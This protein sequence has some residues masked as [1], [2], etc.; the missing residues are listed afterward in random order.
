[1]SEVF[2]RESDLD[3]GPTREPLLEI[4]DLVKHF[5]VRRGLLGRQRHVLRAVD[6]VSLQIRRGET[7]G[8]V[9]ESGCGKSTVGRCLLQLQ[10]VTGGEIRFRGEPIQ[11]LSERALRPLR[12]HIQVVFQDPYE[13]LNPRHTVADILRE[14][15][16][17]HR[18]PVD[19]TS[20]CELL[21]TVGLEPDALNR[22]PHEFSGGQRQRIG[23]AR[24]I[25]LQ[26][27]LLVLDEAVSA[28]DVSVQAQILNLLLGLQARM[29]LTMLFISH[30]LAVVRHIADR[31]AVMYLGRIVEVIDA[32]H[33]ATRARHPYTRLLVAS[34]PAPDK[35]L[36][37]SAGDTATEMP[38]PMAP[39]PGCRFHTRCPRAQP[40]CR[41][42]EPQPTRAAGDAQQWYACHY[43][44]DV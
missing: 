26:P 15:F 36:P 11:Q 35:A 25:A 20:L 3:D 41:V 42:D 28:L 23:I 34:I 44:E 21:A 9:G 7:L 14:P 37:D 43:P 10:R 30:N 4:V 2:I 24:A 29:Q 6:G 18:L 40:R 5:P 33:I 8:L 12:R 13:S 22:Y 27:E 16:F 1:M 38:S 39:P 32:E 31:V 19:R 17:V